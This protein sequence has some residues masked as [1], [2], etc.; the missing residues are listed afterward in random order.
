MSRLLA[1]PVTAFCL[2]LGRRVQILSASFVGFDM[3][4]SCEGVEEF[5]FLLLSFVAGPA[6]GL[7][8]A[9]GVSS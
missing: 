3:H 5:N 2:H 9:M 1:G 7:L 6:T 4:P 8:V